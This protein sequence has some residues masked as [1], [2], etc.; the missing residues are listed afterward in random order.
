LGFA[1][2]LADRIYYFLDTSS[3]LQKICCVTFTEQE[4]RTQGKNSRKRLAF[5]PPKTTLVYIDQDRFEDGISSE[6]IVANGQTIEDSTELSFSHRG[7]EALDAHR[8]KSSSRSHA[9]RVAAHLRHF[10]TPV[11]MLEELLF[12]SDPTSLLRDHARRCVPPQNVTRYVPMFLMYVA[13]N[14]SRNVLAYRTQNIGRWDRSAQIFSPHGEADTSGKPITRA[15]LIDDVC[16]GFETFQQLGRPYSQIYRMTCLRF[17]DCDITTDDRGLK[18]LRRPGG[19]PML[20]EAQARYWIEAVYGSDAITRATRGEAYFREECA[21]SRGKTTESVLYFGERTE[22]DGQWLKERAIM[23]DGVTPHPA[24]IRVTGVDVATGQTSALGFSVDGERASAYR[25]S[26]LCQAM[27]K[28]EYC[29]I[30]GVPISPEQWASAGLSNEDVPDRGVGATPA[31]ES[32]DPSVRATF[33]TM[34]PTGF[35]QGKPNVESD[36]HKSI[37]LRER[38]SHVQTKLSL[39]DIVRREIRRV[40]AH[41]ETKNISSRLTPRLASQVDRPTPNGLFQYFSKTGRDRSRRMHFDDV[42][43]AFATPMTF[44][45]KDGR[46]YYHAQRYGGPKLQGA[47]LLCTEIDGFVVDFVAHYVWIDVQGELIECEAQIALNEDIDQTFVSISEIEAINKRMVELNRNH[48]EHRNAVIVETAKAFED[49]TGQDFWDASRKQGQA[50]RPSK[51][52]PAVSAIKNAAT[53][54][55]N[56]GRR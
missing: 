34:P 19:L 12:S 50:K 33:K 16:A 7:V 36:H 55:A 28:V 20:D 24:I 27:D 41:N 53:P 51:N 6:Q 17:W 18:K 42:I 47:K 40:I 45:V 1:P 49:E 25:M 31:A 23:A 35:G 37:H 43:R 56:S 3:T 39:I 44:Q 38:P 2:F 46:V 4:K 21:P 11:R 26:K 8:N 5:I 54:R 48:G 22:Y 9:D 15:D 30:C 14:F 52:H 10:E 13:S 32:S 29:R